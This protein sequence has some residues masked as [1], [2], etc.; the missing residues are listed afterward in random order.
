MSDIKALV[1]SWVNSNEE[2]SVDFDLLWQGLGYSRKDKALEL[3]Q[4]N[5]DDKDFSTISGKS[6][7]GRPSIGYKL[8][9]ECAKSICM[10]SQTPVGKQVREY[11]IECERQLKVALSQA[12]TNQLSRSEVIEVAFQCLERVRQQE[13][14]CDDKPGLR[15]IVEF[16][17]QP[18]TLNAAKATVQEIA[19]T[20]FGVDLEPGEV[21]SLGRTCATTYRTWHNSEPEKETQEINGTAR[22]VAVYGTE[23]YSTI[24]N[25][26]INKGHTV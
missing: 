5:F 2:F 6:T 9:V 3:L 18:N 12:P 4:R 26:L 25:W 22:L 15:N 21:M 1:R 23:M 24:E 11:F 14:Y 13:R 17:S 10:L 16:I 7:G 19:S 8:S 20:V